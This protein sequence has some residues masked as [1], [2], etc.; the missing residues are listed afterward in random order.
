MKPTITKLKDV[1]GR[2]TGYRAALGPVERDGKTPAEASA[3]CEAASLDAL[4]RLDYVT[5]VHEWRGL[6]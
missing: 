2:I 1:R 4:Q 5:D 3:A 6:H